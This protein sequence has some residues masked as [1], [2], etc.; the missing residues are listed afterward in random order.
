MRNIMK[1]ISVIN[2]KGGVGKTT[3]TSNLAAELA[4]RGKKVLMI[5]LDPQASLTFSFLKP[6][7]W[8]TNVA[9]E[10]TIRNWFVKRHRAETFLD[11]IVEPGEA[12]PFIE[13]NGGVLHLLSSHL[14]L[15]N[16]DLELATGLAGSNLQQAKHN[17]I[18]THSRL[19]E[20]IR[21]IP[22][23]MYDIVLIDC[24]PN[25]NIVTKNAIVASEKILIPAKPDYL[26]TLGIHYLTTNLNKLVKEFNEYCDV[27]DDAN[28][29]PEKINPQIMGVVFT[30]VQYYG[31]APISSLRPYISQIAN[32]GIPVF[33]HQV[34]ENKTAYAD[35]GQYGVP[36]VLNKKGNRP[37]IVSEIEQLVSEIESKW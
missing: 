37:N 2:Y 8:Q 34:R 28:D 32:Q 5:D 7:E 22:E 26:S 36:V 35:A 25:F 1:I 31:G 16:V 27:D 14:D 19:T 21:M 23:G 30:M 12:K 9:A 20:G 29:L 33:A 13:T 11:L 6:D 10:K 3:L 18:A 24:P 15:I 4:Y 17:F